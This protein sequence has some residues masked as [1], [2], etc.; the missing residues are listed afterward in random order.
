MSSSKSKTG[1]TLAGNAVGADGRWSPRLT[2]QVDAVN[3]WF[4]F[5]MPAASTV[6][7]TLD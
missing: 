2:E 3:G 1:V 5:L 4:E 7:I 6:L